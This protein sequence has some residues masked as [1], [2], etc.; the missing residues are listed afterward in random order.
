MNS[1][2]RT[3]LFA[4]LA[5]ALLLCVGAVGAGLIVNNGKLSPTIPSEEVVIN[6][7]NGIAI[8]K[9]YSGI[10]AQNHLYQTFTYTTTPQYI[11]N[12]T[13][14]FT[15]TFADNRANPG[16][17]LTG[18]ST[19]NPN[20]I[21]ITVLQPFNSV[22]TAHISIGSASGSITLNYKQKIDY[23]DITNDITV[24]YD[25][26]PELYD[27]ATAGAEDNHPSIID[28]LIDEAPFDAT[29]QMS[30]VYT[31]PFGT[32]NNSLI[33][34]ESMRSEGADNLGDFDGGSGLIFTYLIH[35]AL[36]LCPAGMTKNSQHMGLY[37]AFDTVF[38]TLTDSQ[39]Q[40]VADGLVNDRIQFELNMSGNAVVSATYQGE[41]WPVDLNFSN[42]YINMEV[43]PSW[44]IGNDATS[45]SVSS[46]THTF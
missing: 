4:G 46:G 44:G 1:K 35:P 17:Y 16:N 30:T 43:M 13:M 32:T 24:D 33:S 9:A 26:N 7:G 20:T 28:L 2:K 6:D 42:L 34:A 36:L 27:Y 37:K 39:K 14:N 41:P 21:T 23:I 18:S 11:A 10:D 40:A 22:A 15:F 38:K 5:T 45:V 31:V 12:K 8:K 19:Y 25:W 3:G 29:Y